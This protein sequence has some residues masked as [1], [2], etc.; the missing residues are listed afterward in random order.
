MKK[1]LP[2]LFY[3]SFIQVF[4]QNFD[5]GGVAGTRAWLKTV[6]NEKN[7]EYEWKNFSCDSIQIDNQINLDAASDIEVINLNFNPSLKVSNKLTKHIILDKSNLSQATIIGVFGKRNNFEE[8]EFIYN[9]KGRATTDFVVTTDGIFPIHE[10]AQ[11]IF[12]YGSE[13]GRDLFF[14]AGESG[15]KDLVDFKET[16]HRILTYQYHEQPNFSIWGEPT[17]ATIKLGDVLDQYPD[18]VTN[19]GSH[20]W[21][22]PEILVY[23]RELEPKERLKAETYLALKYGITLD[24]DYM[25]SRD[26]VIWSLEDNSDYNNRITGIVNDT[27]SGLYQPISHTSNEESYKDNYFSYD[28]D[29]YFTL[30]RT[31]K[32]FIT[33]GD[34]DLLNS[35]GNRLLTIGVSGSSGLLN[36]NGAYA[37]WGDDDATLLTKSRKE[38]AGARLL[39]RVWKINTN[40]S[41]D[42]SNQTVLDNDA[43]WLLSGLEFSDN[44]G[45]ADLNPVDT[46]IFPKTAITTKP[47]IGYNGSVSVRVPLTHQRLALRF[48]T[49]AIA[50]EDNSGHYGLEVRYNNVYILAND[51]N[52]EG[53]WFA[54]VSG[55]ND[56]LELIKNENEV[57]IVIRRFD[58]DTV[59]TFSIPIKDADKDQPFYTSLI[60][61]PAHP[62]QNFYTDLQTLRE[63]SG[64]GFTEAEGLFTELSVK[65]GKANEFIPERLAELNYE[66]YLIIDQSGDG[67]FTNPSNLIFVERNSESVERSTINFKDFLFDED[68]S[69]SDAFTF[70]YKEKDA[71]IAYLTET[72]P[73]C[74]ATDESQ[75]D[76]NISVELQF[77]EAPFTYRLVGTG[78]TTY[79]SSEQTTTARTFA[80]DNITSGDYLLEIT[81]NDDF[82]VTHEVYLRAEC[83]E[84]EDFPDNPPIFAY[85]SNPANNFELLTD[86]EENEEE[87]TDE[88][89]PEIDEEQNI[90]AYPI[91]VKNG[92]PITVRLDI[93]ETVTIQIVAPTG[94]VVLHQEIQ[95]NDSSEPQLLS[96][97]I[98]TTPGIYFLTAIKANGENLNTIKIIVY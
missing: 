50:Q 51:G 37:I 3:I 70:G 74:T 28:N 65:N 31:F 98:Y 78:G 1:L 36:N 63:F 81:D 94:G 8:E 38:L 55:D 32:E 68:G 26:Q 4:S 41:E 89:E 84:E 33:A 82:S 13:V 91:P 88:D 58:N 39:Q 48:G 34:A 77:G 75:N 87:D 72:K 21:N 2:V 67:D 24:K 15:E 54:G 64:S 71:F 9:V 79:D 47:L 69:G 52:P 45:V 60:S 73:T 57:I 97:D 53:T 10:G 5:P 61:E 83:E 40:I 19:Q 25:N 7:G 29:S 11:E 90:V 66:S 30:Y 56:I 22:I 42:L 93:E 92:E 27:L 12:D 43:L 80:I 18:A 85:D 44:K 46:E 20:E 17:E 76:G 16:T 96:F 95:P 23:D 6:Y 35:T 86:E 49:S 62:S 59:K 14:Q